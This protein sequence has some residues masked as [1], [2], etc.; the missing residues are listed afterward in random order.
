MSLI[1]LDNVKFVHY[2]IP[3]GVI[4]EHY[5]TCRGC[6]FSISEV[7]V[8]WIKINQDYQYNDLAN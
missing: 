2:L 5:L 7:I 8:M 4:K 3:S 6:D 1:G